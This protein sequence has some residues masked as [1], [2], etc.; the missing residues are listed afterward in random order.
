[1][2]REW[3]SPPGPPL[4][5]APSAE[6]SLYHICSCIYYMVLLGI[7]SYRNC[8]I[9]TLRVD[10][11]R[12][13]QSKHPSTISLRRSRVVCNI[14]S[15]SQG[16]ARR[17]QVGFKRAGRDCL[18]PPLPLPHTNHP[19]RRHPIL[20]SPEIGSWPGGMFMPAG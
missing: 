2:P 19:Q 3:P 10:F 6:C 1:M 7:K 11:S 15:P 12:S 8:V 13:V 17:C 18:P 9:S 14:R 4:G 5:C 20:D 16:S